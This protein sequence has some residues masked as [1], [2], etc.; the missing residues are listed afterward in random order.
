LLDIAGGGF[1]EPVLAVGG[2]VEWHFL[3]DRLAGLLV[4]HS[5]GELGEIIASEEVAECDPWHVAPGRA[6]PAPKPFP[7]HVIAGHF[8]VG[9]LLHGL[10]GLRIEDRLAILHF[11]LDGRHIAHAREPTSDRLAVLDSACFIT[12]SKS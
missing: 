8:L 7:G 10:L 6:G 5:V 11:L 1:L 4:D 9:D 2:V 3:G 12:S